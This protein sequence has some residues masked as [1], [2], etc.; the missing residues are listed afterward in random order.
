MAM[1][2]HLKEMAQCRC[3]ASTLYAIDATNTRQ[4]P[5]GKTLVIHRGRLLCGFA[6]S[7]DCRRI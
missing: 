3:Q 6:L 1:N 4:L 5:M 7:A 2:L